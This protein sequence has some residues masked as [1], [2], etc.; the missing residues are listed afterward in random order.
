LSTVF[1]EAGSDQIDLLKIDVEGAEVSLFE[2]LDL[3][4]LEGCRQIS[5]EF[6]SFIYPEHA[7]RIAEIK[8]R[9]RRNGFK[10]IDF[11]TNDADVLFVNQRYIRLSALDLAV[12]RLSK[13]ATGVARRIARAISRPR[14]APASAT[15]A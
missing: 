5:I 7:P 9:M 15:A 10:V 14:A 1:Q 3:S 11:S 13:Y 12:L 2:S 6:H 8:R 4:I